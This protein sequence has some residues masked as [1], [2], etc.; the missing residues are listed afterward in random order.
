MAVFQDFEKYFTALDRE[1]DGKD[2]TSALA[3]NQHCAGVKHGSF[4]FV[5]ILTDML[6]KC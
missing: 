6:Q 4:P 1:T 2:L 3:A 5:S